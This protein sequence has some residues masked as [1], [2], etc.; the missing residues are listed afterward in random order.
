MTFLL[1]GVTGI[2]LASPPIDFATHDTY[3]VVAHFHS[4]VMAL[5]MGAFAGFFYW[6]PKI[7]GRMLRERLGK[8][9]FWL[10]FIGTNVTFDPQYLV[11]LRGMPR[12]IAEYAATD[13]YTTL[14]RISSAGAVLLFFSVALFL[15]NLFV[16][17]RKP[18][19]AGDNPWDAS[20]LEWAT[21]SPPPHHN[22]LRSRRSAPSGRSGTTTTLSTGSSTT[23]QPRF[24]ARWPLRTAAAR[25]CS[26]RPASTATTAPETTVGGSRPMKV[27]AYVLLFVGFF[28]GLVGLVYWLLS[29]EDAGSVMLLG[30]FLLGCVPGFYY[31][32]WSRRMNPR[33]ADNPDATLEDGAGV[34]GAFPGSSIWPFVLGLGATFVALALVFGAWTLGVGLFLAV[35]ALVGVVYESRRGGLV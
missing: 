11:G 15:V 2:L 22:F 32:W 20:T 18:I 24:A 31:L 30:T 17:W 8:A 13:G 27:E 9:S 6:Y 29:Y 34:V 16:S 12:R 7:T 1:G 33:P 35:S 25:C 23:A 28:F 3:F 10:M 19:P 4:V 21:T 26:R 5:V 14:N